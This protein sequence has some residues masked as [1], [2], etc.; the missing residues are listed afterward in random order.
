MNSLKHH[1]HSPHSAVKI[2]EW[3][4]RLGVPLAFIVMGAA[5]VFGLMT[6]TGHVTW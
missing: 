4:I 6:S 2:E 1:R 5:L 3:M